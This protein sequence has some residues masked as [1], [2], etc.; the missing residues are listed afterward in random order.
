MPETTKNCINSAKLFNNF[1]YLFFEIH[2]HLFPGKY[3]I[4]TSYNF[5]IRLNYKYCEV[6]PFLGRESNTKEKISE[7]FWVLIPCHKPP[8]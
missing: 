7:R 3:Q 4:G 1:P 8:S 2:N 6:W 5:K